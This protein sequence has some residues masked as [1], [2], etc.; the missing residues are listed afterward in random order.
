[1]MG[2]GFAIGVVFPFFM[3]LL[4]MPTSYTMQPWFFLVCIIAGLIVGAVNILLAKSVVGSRLH[5]IADK[6]KRISG[7]ISSK[8]TRRS[9][10]RAAPRNAW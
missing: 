5:L 3:M 1:M 2:F 9:S 7:Y 10:R 8:T 4:G 6:M